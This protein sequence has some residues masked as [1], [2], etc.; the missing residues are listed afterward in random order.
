MPMPWVDA[1]RSHDAIARLRSSAGLTV[2]TTTAT[3]TTKTIGNATFSSMNTLILRR[4]LQAS[5]TS[6]ADAAV[7][8][9]S[10]VE[11]GIAFGANNFYGSTTGTNSTNLSNATNDSFTNANG[12]FNPVVF[13]GVNAFIAFLLIAACTWCWWCGGW[14]WSATASSDVE[15]RRRLAEQQQQRQLTTAAWSDDLETRQRKIVAS[16]DKCHVKQVRTKNMHSFEYSRV[17]PDHSACPPFCF[18]IKSFRALGCRWPRFRWTRIV[19]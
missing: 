7:A 9:S 6:A 17:M 8:S 4:R 11:S 2:Q 14:K 13:W 19:L 10:A 15:Y 3:A 12:Q 18:K 1:S 16:F 5:S